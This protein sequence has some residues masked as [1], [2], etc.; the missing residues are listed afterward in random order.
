MQVLVLTEAA[1]E[2]TKLASSR[3]FR[4]WQGIA[5]TLLLH[6]SPEKAYRLDFFLRLGRGRLQQS[7][8]PRGCRHS[9]AHA[10]KEPAQ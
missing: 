5:G 6:C 10:S 1:T 4:P 2:V 9:H 8:I 3:A 7:R